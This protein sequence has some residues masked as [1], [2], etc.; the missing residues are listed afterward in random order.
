VTVV[1]LATIAVPVLAIAWHRALR[2]SRGHARPPATAEWHRVGAPAW[3][4]AWQAAYGAGTTRR[5]GRIGVLER[6]AHRHL[7]IRKLP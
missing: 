1:L 2:E 5:E 7:G 6:Q 4:D 3:D